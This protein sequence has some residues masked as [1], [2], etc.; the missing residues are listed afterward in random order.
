[1]QTVS[2]VWAVRRTSRS[3]WVR[4]A[5]KRAG[6]RKRLATA[7]RRCCPGRRTA[8]EVGRR[9]QWRPTAA[10]LRGSE[11]GRVGVCTPPP[12]SPSVAAKGPEPKAR[13]VAVL[14]TQLMRMDGRHRVRL[15]HPVGEP[16][17]QVQVL[18]GEWVGDACERGRRWSE[19]RCPPCLAPA[20]LSSSE[21]TGVELQPVGVER[22][23]WVDYRGR[24]RRRDP[25]RRSHRNRLGRGVQGWGRDRCEGLDGSGLRRH[26]F[27]H[28]RHR[29]R[30][31]VGICRWHA[32]RRRFGLPSRQG[33]QNKH[34][35]SSTL[36]I[37]CTP[38]VHPQHISLHGIQDELCDPP[39][40]QRVTT[41]ADG[42]SGRG[43]RDS[44]RIGGEAT[45]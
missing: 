10:G 31:S 27:A 11:G 37:Q 18:S 13:S 8:G 38:S 29:R 17:E 41:T 35:S 12:P 3:P 40:H 4:I 33:G 28:R 42:V 32:P 9:W 20:G 6:L 22:N 25:R 36:W 44:R 34:T 1:M 16:Q 43:L 26:R 15:A 30:H 7:R 45:P 39:D 5:L 21:H 14:H 2:G 19:G 23:V 24:K